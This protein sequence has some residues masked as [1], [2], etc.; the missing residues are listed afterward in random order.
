MPKMDVFNS[1][2]H[3]RVHKGPNSAGNKSL[4]SYRADKG[5]PG[6]TGY[7]PGP[8]SMGLVVKGFEH[9]G[10]PADAGTLERL[11][12]QT[13]DPKR[14]TQYKE[15]F[16]AGPRDAQPSSKTGGGYWITDRCVPPP[17]PFVA[18]TTYRQETL[19]AAQNAAAQ[20]QRSEG[21]VSTLVGY[22]A[23]RQANDMRRSQSADP[24][25]RAA[26]T[27][28]GIGMQ[29][30]VQRPGSAADPAA[31]AAAAAAASLQ[32]PSTVPTAHGEL[33]GYQT[34]YGSMTDPACKGLAEMLATRP[35]TAGGPPGDARWKVMPR[36]MNPG[37]SRN[38]TSYTQE[39]GADGAD[40]MARQP[41]GAATMTRMA[42]TRDLAHGTTRNTSHIPGYTGHAPASQFASAAGVAQ[43]E[44]AA[45][46]ADLK[47][48][49]L[50]FTLDQYSR[51]RVPGY[52]GHKPQGAANISSTQPAQGPP[53][54]TTAGDANARATR[55]GLPHQ[56]HE[57][58]INSRLGLMTFFNNS[59][60]GTEF[61]SEN[62]LFNAQVYYKECKALGTLGIKTAR[63]P[64]TTYYGAT[65]R[66]AASM[67]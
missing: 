32:R 17:V 54:A 53:T 24:R 49:S 10:R 28:R 67:V 62:G 15:S 50:P 35:A 29:A 4:L 42:A 1:T 20:V 5:V 44:A 58:H 60:A 25:A 33:P 7:I 48:A 34:T 21:L 59:N 43:G 18:T 57:H 31:A 63:P 52:T 61:V 39:Y 23:A 38:Y 47:A 40:P 66:A 6:Y 19:N 26:S 2:M 45:P 13:A 9:T 22:E 51:A 11:T 46:R 65:F 55:F 64:Q 8:S 30:T 12:K 16:K 14:E 27:A 3:D 37:M 36:V 56:S 41:G